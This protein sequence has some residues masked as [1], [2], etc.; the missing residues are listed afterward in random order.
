MQEL[1]SSK[2]DP[3]DLIR[4]EVLQLDPGDYKDQHSAICKKGHALGL[5]KG[6]LVEY[7]DSDNKAGWSP[8]SNPADISIQKYKQLLWNSLE[9][10]FDITGFAIEKLAKEFGVKNKNK[11]KRDG[12]NAE[13][14]RRVA[15]ETNLQ[16]EVSKK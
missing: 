1:D 12:H 8:I 7:Y 3:S 9:E 2:V 15:A 6:D 4:G 16:S 10:V 5:K 11:K 13:R 14:A